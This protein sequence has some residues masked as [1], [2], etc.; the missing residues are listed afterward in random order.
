MW[1]GWKGLSAA[2]ALAGGGACKNSVTR[3][4]TLQRVNSRTGPEIGEYGRL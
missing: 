1:S 4:I 2:D 3:I